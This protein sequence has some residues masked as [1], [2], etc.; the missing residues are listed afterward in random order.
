MSESLNKPKKSTVERNTE[1]ARPVIETL[2]CYE[3]FITD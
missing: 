3:E 2:L 1:Y